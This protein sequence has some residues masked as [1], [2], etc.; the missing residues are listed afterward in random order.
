MRVSDLIRAGGD[1]QQKGYK[2]EAEIIRFIVIDEK[3]R[4]AIRLPID[5]AAIGNGDVSKDIPVEP[6]DTLTLKQVVD[7]RD[8]IT[9]E[10]V[11]EVNYPGAYVAKPGDLLSDLIER[12]GGFGTRA[13]PRAAVFVREELR[14]KEQRQLDQMRERLREELASM[15]LTIAQEDPK[16]QEAY[17]SAQDILGQLETTRAV[18]RLVIDLEAIINGVSEDVILQ[19]GDR[20]M[21]PD[22]PQEVTVIGEVYH[23][24]SHLFTKDQSRNEYIKRSG[25]FTVKADKKRIYVVKANGEVMAP[26]GGWFGS[27]QQPIEV[28]DTIVVPLDVDRIRPLYLWTSVAQIVYQTALAIAAF[29]SV[30]VF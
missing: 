29:N 10:V 19:N 1:L 23:P 26:S 15:Q 25:G 7:W 5:L 14:V 27:G 16:V 2:L 12:A 13:Y 8:V 6:F 4:E 9:V 21:V 20:L 3:R 28:G 11:G 18:G 17:G 24:T 30:G 22:R